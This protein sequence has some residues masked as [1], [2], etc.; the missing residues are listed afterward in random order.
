MLLGTVPF[1]EIFDDLILLKNCRDLIFFASPNRK[2]LL[3]QALKVRWI[4]KAARLY[5]THSS[6]L[7]LARP[8]WPRHSFDKFEDKNSPLFDLQISPF[9]L[10]WDMDEDDCIWGDTDDD[11]NKIKMRNQLLKKLN[12]DLNLNFYLSTC[13]E[14]EL[15]KSKEKGSF[16]IQ[17]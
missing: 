9:V 11:K 8:L 14:K 4:L 6:D 16:T 10:G 1:A 2:H 3:R 12:L 17:Y 13:N 15:M 7:A 5:W